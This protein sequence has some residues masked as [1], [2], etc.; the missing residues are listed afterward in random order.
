MSRMSYRS[1]QIFTSVRIIFALVQFAP[2]TDRSPNL[3]PTSGKFLAYLYGLHFYYY[4]PLRFKRF[5]F[6]SIARS[7][8]LILGV[9]E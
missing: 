6:S 4:I 5:R 3:L 9:Y 7:L 1:L 2:L 8:G